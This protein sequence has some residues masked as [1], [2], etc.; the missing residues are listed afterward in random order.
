[1]EFG[2]WNL[3]SEIA[4][5]KGKRLVGYVSVLIVLCLLAG[6]T[7][8]QAQQPQAKKDD[9][10]ASLTTAQQAAASQI[11]LVTE[12]D[13]NGL[14]VLIKRRPGSLTVAGGLFIRG[15]VQNVTAQNAGIE[16]MM[17]DAM[18]EAS[19]KFPRE[20]LRA[21]LSRMGT[22]ISSGSNY[23][24]SVLALACTRQSFDRSWEIFTDVAL[25]PSLTQDDVSLLRDRRL[26]AMRNE[27]DDPDSFLQKL[28]EQVAYTGHPY[29]IDPSGTADTISKITV[30]D[31]R[32]YH[33][34][35]MQASQLLLVVVGDIEA[36]SLKPLI[37]ASFGKL[38]KGNYKAQTVPSLS[39]KASSVDVTQRRLETNY[40]QGIYAAPSLGETDYF[41]MRVATSI[42][43]ERVFTEVRRRRNL[44]Y[45]PDAFLRTQGANI[46]GIYV[47]TNFSNFAIRIM[48]DE[49]ERLKRESVDQSDIEIVI[50]FYLTQYYLGQETNAAQA[51]TLAQYELIGGGWRSSFEYL[52]RLR[53]VTPADVQ[54]VAKKYMKNMRFV[55]VGDPE[56]VDKNIF[57]SLSAE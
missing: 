36:E 15:G 25:N 50:G 38:P 44:S 57:T 46:G 30:T 21:E 56:S 7:L 55:V 3:E 33:K 37:A 47:T 23:D 2:I 42:L 17:L 18:S 49:I 39:F 32:N 24:F 13:V 51:A 29:A 4:G 11:A 10:K 43:T 48:L 16:S 52:D 6:S 27:G 28:Q 41:P 12:L 5:W 35:V 45:A 1:L 31:L 14:K 22:S 53:A 34:R 9:A 8:V 19:A 20:K 40:I 26:I 54:S